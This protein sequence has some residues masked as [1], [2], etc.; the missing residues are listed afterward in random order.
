MWWTKAE[1][2]ENMTTI[3][4]GSGGIQYRVLFGGLIAGT[5]RS[6]IECPFEYAK[7]KR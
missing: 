3:I 4:P 2:F 1:E 5:A 7:V 6:L